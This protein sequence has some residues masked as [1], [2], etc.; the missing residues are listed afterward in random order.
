MQVIDVLERGIDEGRSGVPMTTDT[1]MN[2]FSM[3]SP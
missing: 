1:L 2:W 3:K